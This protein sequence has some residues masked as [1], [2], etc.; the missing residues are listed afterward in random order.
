MAKPTRTTFFAVRDYDL[1]TT[2]NSGQAF[3]WRP[4]GDAWVGVVEKH[5]VRLR[6]QRNPTQHRFGAQRDHSDAAHYR[7][8]FRI[9]LVRPA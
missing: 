2:L 7:N 3:R 9:L 6:A 5:W 4:D 1:A 8:R